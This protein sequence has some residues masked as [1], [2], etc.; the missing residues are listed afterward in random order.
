M[1]EPARTEDEIHD[2]RTIETKQDEEADARVAATVHRML[3]EIG[4]S[5]ECVQES[6][7]YEDLAWWTRIPIVPSQLRVLLA[8]VNKEIDTGEGYGC[9]GTGRLIFFVKTE[10]ADRQRSGDFLVDRTCDACGFHPEPGKRQYLY[11]AVT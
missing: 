1:N 4:R 11:W 6:R 7:L 5:N 10:D 3:E 2:P 9:G 8:N